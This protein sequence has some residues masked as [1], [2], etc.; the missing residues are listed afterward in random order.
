MTL[1]VLFFAAL[2]NVADREK[3]IV[4][5]PGESSVEELFSQLADRY[6]NLK[7]WHSHL[8]WAVNC[9]YVP[10]Q[11]KLRDGDEICFIPPLS[12]G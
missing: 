1:T 8:R 5:M 7:E 4:E 2:R 9:E 11:T 10:A 3:I 12:G 6:P